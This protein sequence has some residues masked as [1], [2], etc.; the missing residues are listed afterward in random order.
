MQTT[1][2]VPRRSS[3]VLV[4]AQLF[5][6]PVVFAL[7][8]LIM[9]SWAG[10]IPALAA[11]VNVSH[12]ALSMVLLCGGLGAVISYPISS[13]LMARFGARKTIMIAGL[14]LLCVL[15]SIGMAPDVSRLMMAVLMLGITASTFD[16]AM[17]SAAARR[18]KESGKSEMSRLHGLCCA[19]GLVGATLG[20]LMASMKI[21]P[22][23]HFLMLAG[24]LAVVLWLAVNLLEAD[25]V[26]EKVEKKKFA[27]PR[28]PLVLLGLLGFFGSMAEGSIADW[29]GVFLKEHFGASDGLAPLALSSFSLMMLMSRMVGDKMKER[30]GAK[31]LVTLGAL[32][33]ASGL[34]FAV[35]APNA[36][37]A[38][39]G[40]AIA[41]VGLALVFPFV[42]SAAGAQGPAALAA[43]AS[44]AYSGSLMGPPAIGAV[45]HFV[46]MQAAIAYVGGLSLVIAMVACRTRLLK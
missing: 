13:F 23:T 2:S 43:V 4:Q 32:V 44:M 33:A 41:G 45:A 35:L 9:G 14:A 27:L 8:G 46:G 40:F 19:G 34:F 17:N 25:E 15:V 1:V 11:G 7:F 26:G 39:G 6:L 16:V 28:G 12:A 3:S 30:Y 10:R 29:S 20:S 22:A 38:L 36:Y 5:S 42:F 21:A 37:V 18:E 31:R 24:P